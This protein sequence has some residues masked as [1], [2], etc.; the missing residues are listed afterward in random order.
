VPTEKADRTKVTKDLIPLREFLKKYLVKN[1]AGRKLKPRN[2]QID[3]KAIR[4][5]YRLKRA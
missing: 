1:L 4:G 5:I 2:G 3:V